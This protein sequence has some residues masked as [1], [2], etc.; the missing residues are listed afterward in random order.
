MRISEDEKW[1]FCIGEPFMIPSAFE[2][3][4]TDIKNA[5]L[6]MTPIYTSIHKGFGLEILPCE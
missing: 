3:L 5:E 4:E 1:V 2:I 6:N